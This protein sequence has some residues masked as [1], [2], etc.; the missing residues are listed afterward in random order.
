MS[1]NDISGFDVV[2][3]FALGALFGAGAALLL[4]PESGEETRKKIAKQTEETKKKIFEKSEEL[5]EKSSEFLEE[6]KTT[7]ENFKKDLNKIVTETRGSIK[8]SIRE[9]LAELEKRMEAKKRK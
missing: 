9:E 1:D 3:A 7:L 5:R 2:K 8:D 4:A 6:G